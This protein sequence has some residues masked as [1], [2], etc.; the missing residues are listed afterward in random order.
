MEFVSEKV[1][2]LYS[3]TGPVLA[4][5]DS[6]RTGQSVTPASVRP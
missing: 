1:W 2:K 5:W 4:G 3:K 6:A